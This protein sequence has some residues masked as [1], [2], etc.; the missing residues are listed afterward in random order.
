M[1]VPE[2]RNTSTTV[3]EN[4]WYNLG[5]IT[6]SMQLLPSWFRL[7]LAS[8]LWFLGVI[9][10]HTAYAQEAVN[11][12]T[13]SVS[14]VPAFIRQGGVAER[15]SDVVLTCTGGTPA[16]SDGGLIPTSFNILL[17]GTTATRTL[18]GGWTESLAV[19]DEPDFTNQ[20]ACSN[21][22]GCFMT[23]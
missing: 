15:T 21:P 7:P 6:I 4:R 17:S 22:E 23:G 16:A 9:A 3:M 18:S 19:V 10:P 11:P 13:C 8:G 20:L 12:I 5:H 2:R 14:T 1:A